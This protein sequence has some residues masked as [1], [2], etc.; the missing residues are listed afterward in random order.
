MNVEKC[1]TQR[2]SNEGTYRN[3][4]DKYVEKQ[5]ERERRERWGKERTSEFKTRKI[6]PVSPRF[7]TK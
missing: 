7:E 4:R 1:V 2:Q 5:S 6:S 3:S